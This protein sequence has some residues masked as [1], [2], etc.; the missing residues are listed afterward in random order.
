MTTVVCQV[1]GDEIGRGPNGL[2]LISHAN[3][4]RREFTE[5][6]GRP[7]SDYEEVRQ[8]LGTSFPAGQLT[9]W[10]S[11]TDDEQESIREVFTE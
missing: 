3:K 4:H 5:I 6:F 1:C 10:E 11:L 8:K 2:G 7:P 9:L